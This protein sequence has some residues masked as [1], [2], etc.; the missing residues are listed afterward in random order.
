[1]AEA[2]YRPEYFSASY[3]GIPFEAMESTSEHGRRGAEGEFPFGETTA[4]ADLGRRIRTYG[5]RGRFLQNDH[6]ARSSA[7]IAVCE[8]LG[9]G[10]LMHPTRGLVMVACKSI[11]VTDDPVEEQGCTYVDLEF[12]EANDWLNGL[13]FGGPLIAVV[14][15]A[16]TAA[17]ELSFN[18]S[19]T[20]KEV[21]FY[22]RTALT[23]TAS[24]A[25]NSLYTN[26]QIATSDLRETK[27]YRA[28]AAFEAL[29]NDPLQLDDPALMF[30]SIRDGMSLIDKFASPEIKSSLFL[31]LINDA[32]QSIPLLS[33]SALTV[34]A[35]L[36]A[37][38]VLGAGYLARA[39]M[40]TVPRD[41]DQ[42]L[43]QYD[44]VAAV[45]DQE[46]QIARESC[47]NRLFLSVSDFAV[48]TKS[49]LLNRAYTLPALVVYKF[50][51]TLPSLV[52]AYE[53]WSD[54]SR[55]PEIEA[56]NVVGLPWQYGPEII[57][58]R[59]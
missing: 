59:T 4:Y 55:F 37:M 9:P 39:A 5:I 10:P 44:Q 46:A 25:I 57:A 2:C 21:P 1:M 40:E 34:N 15:S 16:I 30:S 51:G 36:T 56:Q 14:L 42:A 6:I 18:Q 7:L 54:A 26:F 3:K 38:R 31:D 47:D 12:V 50:P 43:R 41:M 27:I 11:R 49:A 23:S 48:E 53:I 13:N 35:I 52:V 20:P 29:I 17:V 28:L 24:R 58:A 33:V 19:Y 45:L 22:D 32:S 8:S